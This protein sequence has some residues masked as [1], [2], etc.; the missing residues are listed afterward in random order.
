LL[1]DAL[2]R[3]RDTRWGDCTLLPVHDELIVM[4]P[5]CDAQE[6]TTELARCME[7]DLYGV[8]IVAEPSTPSFAWQDS[9]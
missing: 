2:V 6:A 3:W 9:V 8:K 4:V 7:G 1:V 5:E